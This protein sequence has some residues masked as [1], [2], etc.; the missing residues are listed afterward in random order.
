[1]S[2]KPSAGGGIWDR[3]SS[4]ERNLLAVLICVA[5]LMG[6]VGMFFWRSSHFGQ[7]RARIDELRR[8][9]DLVY[10]RGSVFQEKLEQKQQREAKI[11]DQRLEFS[12][13]LEEATR[14]V[15]TEGENDVKLQEPKA[16][17]DLGGGLQKRVYEFE[18]RAV[19]LADLLEF[20]KVV[21]TKKGHIIYS[22]R[23]LIHS[24]SPVE[25]RLNAEVEL[26]TWERLSPAKEEKTP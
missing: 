2:A 3:L 10:K 17:L 20:I 26:A 8:G 7:E 21:E 16:S 22:E 5:L 11:S 14:K 9:L 4:R 23:L 18:L 19:P 6:I 15:F 24:P 25:D 1:M 13:L 12:L